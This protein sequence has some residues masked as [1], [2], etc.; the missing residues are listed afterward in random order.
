MTAKEIKIKLID[1]GFTESTLLNNR[2]LI[3]A[4][5][6]EVEAYEKQENEQLKQ[7]IEYLYECYKSGDFL[8]D[9]VEDEIKQLINK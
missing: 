1:R 7:T 8:I 2:G 4:I 5:L 9:H 3:G 6:D